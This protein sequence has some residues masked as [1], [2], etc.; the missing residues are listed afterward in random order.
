MTLSG[1]I[2]M[3]LSV[4][5]VSALLVWC[6]LKVLSTPDETEHVHGFEQTPPDA[7]KD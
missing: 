1:W 6:V 5:S 4:G 7:R 3:A 2:I